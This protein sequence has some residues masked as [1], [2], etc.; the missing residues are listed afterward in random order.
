M[1]TVTEAG[2]DLQQLAS[3]V[4]KKAL[5][6]G[7]SDAEVVIREGDEF[8]TTVRLGQVETLKE[9][10]SRGIGL[11]VFL[12]QRA[13]STSSSDFSAAGIEH[14]VGGAI[15]LARV[16]SEDPFAGLAEAS[17]FGQITSDLKLYHEDVH[18]LP[19]AERIEYARRTEAAAL[20]ADTRLHNSDGGS[21]DAT[22]GRK[23]LANSRGFVGESRGSYCSIS[24]SPIALGQSGEMQRDYWYSTARSVAKLDSPEAVGAEAA[25]RTLRRL[26]GRRVPTQQ[27]PIVFAPEIARSLIGAIFDAASGDS[28]YR[29]ASFFTG[30]LGEQ[31]AA[32]SVNVIDDGTLVGGFG[33]SPFDGEGLPKRR[34]VIVERGVLTNYLLNTYTARKLNMRSTGNAARGLSGNPGIGAS[35]L[36]LE[37]GTLTPAQIIGDIGSGLYVT[38]LIGQGVNM[39]TG[40]YSR[41]ASGLWIENGELT[42]PVQE[43]TIAGNLKEMFMN[44]SAIGND[45]IFRS[46]AA[47]PTLR[48]DG[49]TIAG[50]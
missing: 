23:V 28:I 3:D 50:S 43:I 40:D 21:F 22:T 27:A 48:V 30:K 19:V 42:Y 9:S 44:I 4:V 31:V 49:M 32:E 41:G 10:G 39:V 37:A 2:T 24:T 6:A 46:S 7:A 5:A 35:N 38:E 1:T 11:R 25:R 45:L 17:E 36:F 13:A 29:G 12:G 8:S 14:L 47:A 20:A 15:A 16:T 34:T 18:S 26:D 33:S